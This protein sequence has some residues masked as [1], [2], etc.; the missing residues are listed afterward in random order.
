M[1]TRELLVESRRQHDVLEADQVAY[2]DKVR[3]LILALIQ[4]LQ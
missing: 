1:V 2:G 3:R 4:N